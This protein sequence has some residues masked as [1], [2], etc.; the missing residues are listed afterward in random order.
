M[1]LHAVTLRMGLS[2]AGE[3]A[4]FAMRYASARTMGHGFSF[5]QAPGEFRVHKMRPRFV[6]CYEHG[7]E[8]RPSGPLVSCKLADHLR[9]GKMPTSPDFVCSSDLG[10]SARVGP[11]W[12]VREWLPGL[13]LARAIQ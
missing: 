12:F 13:K 6:C 7:D 3:A 2:L 10:M 8:C 4:A 1:D 11:A 5:R 9:L